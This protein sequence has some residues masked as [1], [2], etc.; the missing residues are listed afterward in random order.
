LTTFCRISLPP[1]ELLDPI[2]DWFD[3]WITT[4]LTMRNQLPES[5]TNHSEPSSR[6]SLDVALSD[7]FLIG[8]LKGQLAGRAL[9]SVSELVDKIHEIG[10]IIPPA[11]SRTRSET[12]TLHP[13][14]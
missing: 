6:F 12:A 11:Q 14:Q 1:R 13:H 8:A 10:S 4:L 3:K 9:E 5:W 7:V 2:G